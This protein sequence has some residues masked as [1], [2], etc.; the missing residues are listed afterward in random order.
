MTDNRSALSAIIRDL[1]STPKVFGRTLSIRSFQLQFWGICLITFHF[2]ISGAFLEQVGQWNTC[3]TPSPG[4]FARQI[5]ALPK[6]FV[7]R[8]KK[9]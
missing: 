9:A 1:S 6:M 5:K 3:A 2:K 7:F 8:Y 4:N